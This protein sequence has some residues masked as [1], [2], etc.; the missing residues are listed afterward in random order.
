[1]EHD[2]RTALL[3]TLTLAA[4]ALVASA[5]HADVY[6]HTDEKGNVLYTDKPRTLPAQRLDV[7]T[8]K[9]DTVAVQARQEADMKRMQELNQGRKQSASAQADQKEASE[10]SA[11]DKAERC[12]K[13][14]ERYDSYMNSQRLF[15][16]LPNN[17]RRY[18]TDAELDTARNSAKVSMETLCN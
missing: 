12:S 1:M 16:S 14:R 17:E 8:Q 15:E 4:F 7:K 3:P 9:T 18:L 2:M 11:K 10:L 6:K 5:A 13:A